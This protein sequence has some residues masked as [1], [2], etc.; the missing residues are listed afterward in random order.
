MKLP[1]G[2]V[3]ISPS[4][5]A[6]NFARLGSEIQAAEAGGAGLLHFDVMDGHFVPNLTIGVPVLASIR[7]VAKVPLEVHLMIDNPG[8]FVE[9]FARAGADR[10]YIHQE[11]TPH[12][13]RVLH[14]IR[15]LGAEPGVAINPSTPA[16]TLSEVLD[17]VGAVLVMSV[18]PGFGGQRFIARSILKIR[19]LAAMRTRYNSNFRIA[20]DGGVG[21][22]NVAEIVRAGAEVMVAGTSVFH[23][24]DAAEAVRGLLH[25]AQEALA[26]Q[27]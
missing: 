10:I 5:L 4:I 7:P 13:D 26:L 21:L 27:V 14:H 9:P 3:E 18:N 8:E 17:L 1:S 11:A 6:A 12:L 25:R 23:A 15:E 2:R 20:V 22:E 19:E 24:S 16:A